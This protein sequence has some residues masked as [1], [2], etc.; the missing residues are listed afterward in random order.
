MARDTFL[1]KKRD[2]MVTPHGQELR[3]KT[4][5]YDMALDLSTF[6]MVGRFS[7]RTETKDHYKIKEFCS[8]CIVRTVRKLWIE[9][10]CSYN[11]G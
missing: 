3:Q 9:H 2:D 8:F 5:V 1:A 7:R 11:F 6:S 10:F 4:V